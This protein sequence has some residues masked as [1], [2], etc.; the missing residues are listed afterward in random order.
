MAQMVPRAPAMHYRALRMAHLCAAPRVL[1]GAKSSSSHP[2]RLSPLQ[3]AR[4]A[5]RAAQ[6]TQAGAVRVRR[7][8][9][10]RYQ[11]LDWSELGARISSA[12]FAGSPRKLSLFGAVPPRAKVPRCEPVLFPALAMPAAVAAALCKAQS[13]AQAQAAIVVSAETIQLVR[14]ALVA[15]R[16][17][18]LLRDAPE[19]G[20]AWLKAKFPDAQLRD[21]ARFII[22]CNGDQVKA[23]NRWLK[24][25]AWR[26]DELP[27]IVHRSP[28]TLDYSKLDGAANEDV[29]TELGTGKMVVRGHDRQGRPLMIW[30]NSAHQPAESKPGQV[31]PMVVYL[32]EA[33]AAEMERGEEVHSTTMLIHTAKG[34][35]AD[36]ALLKG[37]GKLFAEQYPERLGQV[38]VF[39]VGTV[40]RWLWSATAPFLPARTRKKVV[41]LDSGT[42]QEDIRKY[43]DGDQLQARFGGS[44][45]WEFQKEWEDARVRAQAR[46]ESESSSATER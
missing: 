21:L 32:M 2:P 42:W 26:G 19:A 12:K 1:A 18:R 33:M 23:A 16:G 8:I 14:A 37:A 36:F 9:A 25:A 29:I 41:L 4:A 6:R 40:S 39:P 30:D 20:L 17:A 31:L 5:G 34:S 24:H 10:A 11:R 7:A 27:Q 38:L 45:E 28:P 44:D 35:K 43:V 15:E 3:V 22:A 46:E 13:A